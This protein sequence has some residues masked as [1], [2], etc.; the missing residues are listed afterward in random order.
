MLSLLKIKKIKNM[1]K[2]MNIY[3]T[4]LG[5]ELPGDIASKD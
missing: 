5:Y 3:F 4:E 1:K 2:N